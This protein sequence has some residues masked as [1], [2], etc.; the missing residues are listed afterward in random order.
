VRRVRHPGEIVKKGQEIEV[1][2]LGF[3]RNERRIA[4][5]LKQIES[6]PWDS[7]EREYPIRAR[8]EGS[9]VRVLEKGVVVMLPLGVEGFIPNSQLGRSLSGDSK[10]QI[11]DGDN[12]ELEV[13]EFDKIN[14]RIVLSHS[15]VERET[16]KSRYSAYHEG[17][18]DAKPT[19]ADIMRESKKDKTKP[20]VEADIEKDTGAVIEPVV[21]IITAPESDPIPE[22]IVE[23]EP[24]AAKEVE[25][26]LE[27]D[28]EAEIEPE[29]SGK[30]EETPEKTPEKEAD[31]TPIAKTKK[32]EA[33]AKDAKKETP[34]EADETP[35]AKTKK[36]EINVKTAKDELKETPAEKVVEEPK[37]KTV[38]K[39]TTTKKTPKTEE[40]STE[41]VKKKPAAKTKKVSAK[42]EK[43][44]ET[45]VKTPKPKKKPVKK[46]E[47]VVD[48]P[49]T[50]KTGE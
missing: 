2:V 26:K 20:S 8:T 33:D 4:L 34:A 49:S 3:D 6:D 19:M 7:F 9:V 27:K 24:V 35:I 32:A 41:K 25:A 40:S 16:E 1:I 21:E 38:K 10:R 22:I 12:M 30:V 50:E 11:R 42:T 15:I 39:K 23:A 47:D 48:K 37:K 28:T 17:N 18:E 43:K 13:I 45:V 31:E 36:A 14:H 5:G 44:K 46:N 29:D